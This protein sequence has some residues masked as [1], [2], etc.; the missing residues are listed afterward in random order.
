M[1]GNFA[2]PNPRVEVEHGNL[3]PLLTFPFLAVEPC[4]AGHDRHMGMR[5]DE[6]RLSRPGVK[7]LAP[8]G[9]VLTLPAA[10]STT[11]LMQ[12]TL[13]G[14]R[15]TRGAPPLQDKVR[16]NLETTQRF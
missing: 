9:I 11:Y 4:E 1:R 14:L 16:A 10:Y 8:V 2:P 13:G 12:K 5:L 15:K 7:K 3:T 6:S